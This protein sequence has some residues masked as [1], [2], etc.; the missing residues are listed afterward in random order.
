MQQNQAKLACSSLNLLQ[1][2]RRFKTQQRFK[3]KFF[4]QGRLSQYRGRHQ[5]QI[6]QLLIAD[7]PNFETLW[8][9]Q[10]IYHIKRDRLREGQLSKQLQYLK[11][12]RHPPPWELNRWYI[13]FL[14]SS[15]ISSSPSMAQAADSM[16]KDASFM[17][18][19]DAPE[20]HLDL[21]TIKAELGR[22]LPSRVILQ[23][24]SA[25][26]WHSEF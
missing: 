8:I 6:D 22:Y 16:E 13:E 21:P 7:D 5:L 1:V 4:G 23:G 25:K 14:W 2:W 17:S 12:W 18:A 10:V 26:N 15:S 9:N 24:A 11:V 3:L 20:I 19:E